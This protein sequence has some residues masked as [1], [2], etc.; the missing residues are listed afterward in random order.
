ML[1]K[2]QVEKRRENERGGIIDINAALYR[3]T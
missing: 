3:K 2:M 1:I